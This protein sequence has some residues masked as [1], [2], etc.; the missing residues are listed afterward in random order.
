M[1]I[2]R[3]QALE[4]LFVHEQGRRQGPGVRKIGG[5]VFCGVWHPHSLWS[6]YPTN[7]N[8]KTDETRPEELKTPQPESIIA[9]PRLARACRHAE[10]AFGSV[11]SSCCS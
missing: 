2:N 11:S 10:G 4:P 6:F 3:M 9:N 5:T 8:T 1:T 7:K